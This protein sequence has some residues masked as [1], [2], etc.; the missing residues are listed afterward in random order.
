MEEENYWK[1]E[2]VLISAEPDLQDV[3]RTVAQRLAR[4][5]DPKYLDYL[6]AALEQV[7]IVKK[8]SKKILSKHGWMIEN[9]YLQKEEPTPLNDNQ[10]D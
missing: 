1:I 5:E 3:A 9:G 8:S 6:T 7:F 4:A 2:E 10:K